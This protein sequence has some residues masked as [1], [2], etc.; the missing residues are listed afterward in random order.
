M[1]LKLIKEIIEHKSL[2][3]E[4]K[5]QAILRVLSEDKDALPYLLTIIIYERD[6]QKSIIS[7]LNLEVS[8]YHIH[9]QDSKL[10]KQNKEF[11]NEQTKTLYEKWKDFI[12]PLFNNKF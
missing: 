7:D 4:Y 8:R 2:S 10:L 1:D 3:E 6:T 12:Q 9:I 11:L 5:A